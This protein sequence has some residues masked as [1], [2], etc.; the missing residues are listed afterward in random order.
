MEYVNCGNRFIICLACVAS[1]MVCVSNC[2]PHSRASSSLTHLSDNMPEI[3]SIQS[4]LAIDPASGKLRGASDAYPV[5]VLNTAKQVRV[6]V[7]IKGL[8]GGETLTLTLVDPSQTE[9][10]PIVKQYGKDEQG[11]F[12]ATAFFAAEAWRI[13]P[14]MIKAN[15]SDVAFATYSFMVTP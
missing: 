13:G 3:V 8:R 2:R 5:R 14:H 4:A 7:L 1:L 15:I 11:D 9:S 12:Y 10:E 6:A